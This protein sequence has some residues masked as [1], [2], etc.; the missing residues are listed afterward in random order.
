MAA[1]V[2]DLCGGKLIMGA[3]GIATCESCGMEH[4]ADRMKEKVQEIKG[5][6]KV[7]NSHLIG[8]YLQMANR[9]YEVG[10]NKEAENYC[11][12]IIEIEPNNY[13]ALMIKGKA[14]GWQSTLQ[15]KRF[16]EAINCFSS[17]I[18][19]APDDEKKNLMTDAKS[20]IE[21]LSMAIIKLQGERFEKW[22]DE[23]EASGMLNAIAEIYKALILFITNIDGDI[24]NKD[25]L[26]AH[27][28]TKINNSVMNAWNSKIV[29][30]YRNDSDGH[31]DDYAFKQLI[32]RGNFCINLLLQAIKLSSGDDKADIQRYGNLIAI[33]EYILNSCSYEYKTVNAGN[34]FIDGSTIWENRYCKK[35]ELNDAAKAERRNLIAEYCTKIQNIKAA[36]KASVKQAFWEKFSEE[37]KRLDSEAEKLRIKKNDLKNHNTGYT[38][39]QYINE[40]LNQIEKI[41]KKDR[42]GIS[43]LS[44][45]EKQFI[46]SESSF[47][48]T[49]SDTEDYD[50]YLDKY[51]ILKQK[52]A[53]E[54]EL[55]SLI[56][57]RESLK[58]DKKPSR[59]FYVCLVFAIFGFACMFT[60]D[61]FLI[62]LSLLEMIVGI[63]YVIYFIINII[64]KN[65]ILRNIDVDIVKCQKVLDEIAKIPKYK[66]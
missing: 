35:L 8:N 60:G 27:I 39:I 15:N 20:Q 14:A 55:S 36:E 3:G 24:I 19:S 40:R 50:A 33:Q 6:V 59:T 61:S 12:K 43:T 52:E 28:A 26:M 23:D 9:A 25:V 62:G 22:P 58:K 44:E 11:N 47:W 51:P 42:S 5:T 45:N 29:P 32:S 37:K 31:P 4:S 66:Q 38:Q 7:D 64:Q 57:R 34:S 63:P 1:L 54:T 46:D 56:E 49:L 16:A 13:Q 41:L 48:Q 30:E 17:A 65:K 10:N 53:Q 21:D 18:M 2:C